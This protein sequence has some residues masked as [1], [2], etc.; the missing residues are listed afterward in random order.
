[1][2]CCNVSQYGIAM[3]D[4]IVEGIVDEMDLAWQG[5]MDL[6]FYCMILCCAVL[7]VLSRGI[8]EG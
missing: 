6:R 7:I 2:L 1:M 5:L 4:F 8:I 3:L